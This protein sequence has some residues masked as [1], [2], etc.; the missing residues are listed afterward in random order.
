MGIFTDI[1]FAPFSDIPIFQKECFRNQSTFALPTAV[2]SVFSITQA[3]IIQSLN[4][5]LYD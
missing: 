3:F 1:P 5:I 4:K 2:G